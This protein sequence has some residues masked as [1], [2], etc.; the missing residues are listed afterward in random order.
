MY[1][2]MAAKPG[3]YP[4]PVPETRRYLVKPDSRRKGAGRVCDAQSGMSVIVS[5]W[6]AKPETAERFAYQLDVEAERRRCFSLQREH[7]GAG[8]A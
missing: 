2:R 5:R 8:T 3:F 7:P 6:F 4:D 1:S